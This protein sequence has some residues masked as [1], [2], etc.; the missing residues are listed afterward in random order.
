V[1]PF[2]V[3]TLAVAAWVLYPLW[4]PSTAS[5]PGEDEPL[6]ELLARRDATY[7]AIKE[8]EFDYELGNLSPSDHRDLEAKY[9]DRAVS[10][11]KEIDAQSKGGGMEDEI[12]RRVRALRRHPKA[13]EGPACPQ[14]GE[15]VEARAKFCPGC[16]AEL[17]L[18]CPQCGAGYG[19]GDRFC[20]QCGAALEKEAP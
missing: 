1:I 18:L 3:L 10:I 20:S 8:L 4:R 13:P 7:S 5:E 19:P 9:K 11:L 15:K 17:D 2:I 6:R 16:G 12:E 14:C